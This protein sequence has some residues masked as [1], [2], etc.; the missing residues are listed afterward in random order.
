MHSQGILDRFEL[1][2]YSRFSCI[3]TW[4]GNV[5]CVDLFACAQSVRVDYGPGHIMS[6]RRM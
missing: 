1:C 6:V 4:A 5:M 2:E 3:I